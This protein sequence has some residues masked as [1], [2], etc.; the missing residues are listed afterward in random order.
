MG[1]RK[2][3]HGP[4]GC[5]AWVTDE[6]RA[7]ARG[8]RKGVKAGGECKRHMG[9][10]NTRNCRERDRS[11]RGLYVPQGAVWS[12]LCIPRGCV[13]QG[14]AWS[15]LPV[16]AMLCRMESHDLTATQ[17]ITRTGAARQ[18]RSSKIIRSM[19]FGQWQCGE[20]HSRA[21]ASFRVRRLHRQRQVPQRAA[22]LN[23]C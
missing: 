4:E 20:Q 19:T 9:Q 12:G 18:G 2:A 17:K 6:C 21:R 13:S 1:R 16:F 15:G 7:R 22:V 14:A 23:A 8:G 3:G 11:R 5:H 10:R